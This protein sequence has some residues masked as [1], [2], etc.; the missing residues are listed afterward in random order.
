[1]LMIAEVQTVWL[2]P[3]FIDF[4]TSSKFRMNTKLIYTQIVKSDYLIH[5]KTRSQKVSLLAKL[6]TVNWH[7]WNP[8]DAP[9]HAFQVVLIF[10]FCY[11]I[12]FESVSVD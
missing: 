2:L 4:G 11:S 7:H 8:A 5:I 6:N 1:M 10:V 9:A 3:V 12:N